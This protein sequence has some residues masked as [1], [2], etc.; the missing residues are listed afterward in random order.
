[1][2]DQFLEFSTRI[3]KDFLQTAVILDEQSIFDSDVIIETVNNPPG[4]EEL[5]TPQNPEIR[6]P[7][8]EEA[9]FRHNLDAKKILDTFTN[10]GIICSILKPET[11][12]DYE[13][14]K[15]NYIK[16]MKKA[17]IIILDWNLF[18]DGGENITELIRSSLI[19]PSIEG[20]PSAL[21][22]III[23]SADDLELIKARL[24]RE[25][26][27]FFNEGE[28]DSS[29]QNKFTYI[30]LYN[31]P[32]PSNPTPGRVVEFN[33]LIE[34]C[35][36]E[37]TQ[38]FHGIVPNV[39]MAGI[40]KIRQRTH[41]ILGALNNSLDPAYLSHRS[42]LP[43]P[44]EA[45]QHLEEILTKEI[46]NIISENQIGKTSSFEN[47]Q[48]SVHVRDKKYQGIKF[49][50]CLKD[51]V[52]K[53]LGIL[54]PSLNQ[55]QKTKKTRFEKHLADCYTHQWLR[56]DK[57]EA[58]DSENS[59]AALSSTNTNYSTS[60]KILTSGVIIRELG[61]NNIALLCLQPKCDSVRLS[62]KTTFLFITLKAATGNKADFIIPIDGQLKKYRLV[63]RNKHLIEFRPNREKVVKSTNHIFISSKEPETNYQ[64][65]TSL[66]IEQTQ[67]VIQKFSNFLAR[68]GLNES[69][70]LRRSQ[71]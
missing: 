61:Q 63:Q 13:V 47:I 52:E 17:D 19:P 59:F 49:T 22:L 42:L 48:H 66:T 1:M 43:I 67:R 14:K 31:K 45:E 9:S 55:K 53:T 46:G 2:P 34:V 65:L 70:Y 32:N 29:P 39:A 68:I 28:Y 41:Q 69:E 24:I 38:Q 58:I 71:L 60:E 50:E 4:F 37:F 26:S 25:I 12:D 57:T 7:Y 44:S 10:H 11:Q 5:N 6:T 27:I 16:L 40:S 62:S 18:N 36:K 20:S 54:S 56:K 8:Y 51:G 30:S 21:R 33:E 3:V 23:Y 15:E 35:I 64:F